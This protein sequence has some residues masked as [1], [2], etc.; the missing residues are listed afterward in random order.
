MNSTAANVNLGHLSKWFHGSM[1]NHKHAVS[2]LKNRTVEHIQLSHNDKP[3]YLSSLQMASNQNRDR[4]LECVSSWHEPLNN[5]PFTNRLPFAS[6]I[7]VIFDVHYYIR[8][9]NIRC[10]HEMNVL[11]ITLAK[12]LVQCVCSTAL[13]YL[14]NFY[15]QNVKSPKEHSVI[16]RSPPSNM[17]IHRWK[18]GV[19]KMLC[20]VQTYH[21]K[22]LEEL[23][24]NVRTECVGFFHTYHTASGFCLDVT[25]AGVA[26]SEM[27]L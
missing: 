17:Q 24:G 11:N 22:T 7:G 23:S 13:R 9:R 21:L 15:K 14:L 6:P 19:V 5:T 25:R 10:S 4:W 26:C 3:T 16:R 2:I 12:A 18:E 27:Y 8:A 20:C 1:F